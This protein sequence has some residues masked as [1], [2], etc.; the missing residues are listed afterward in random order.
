MIAGA[1]P[2]PHRF[3]V[4]G[5]AG[6]DGGGWQ[7]QSEAV[8]LKSAED[9]SKYKMKPRQE[10]EH[11][12][13]I[14]VK[15]ERPPFAKAEEIEY[16]FALTEHDRDDDPDTEDETLVY[17]LPGNQSGF[18]ID[19]FSGEP[20]IPHETFTIHLAYRYRDKAG[21]AGGGWVGQSGGVDVYTK[22]ATHPAELLWSRVP[23]VFLLHS[24]EFKPNK[25]IITKGLQNIPNV[26]HIC[27]ECVGV[28]LPDC[29]AH[30]V[31]I[32]VC[33]HESTCAVSRYPDLEL[34][35][36]GHVN[37]G[38]GAK[39]AKKL[40]L[41]RATTVSHKLRDEGVDESRLTPEGH[42]WS[43]P[44]YCLC[45]VCCQDRVASSL[46]VA[47]WHSFARGSPMAGKNRRVDFVVKKGGPTYDRIVSEV[48]L[49]RDEVCFGDSKK[50]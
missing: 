37:F 33:A 40:S 28:A 29:V 9:Y 31:C 23:R 41:L 13:Y 50:K 22:K 4:K 48:E 17:V 5:D 3:R 49:R 26:A 8:P 46:T 44:R 1:Q 45:R 38:Q 42:G 16:Q 25:G 12:A 36:E 21:D 20:I 19:E 27:Q 34:L 39:A 18:M 10:G 7:C 2:A 11:L 6:Y 35:V 47:L 30:S 43:R 14:V 15:W 24:L 32:S